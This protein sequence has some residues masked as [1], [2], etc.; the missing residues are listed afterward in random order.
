VNV[1]SYEPFACLAGG[2]F[3][4]AACPFLRNT[5]IAFSRS[6]WA[7]IN[8]AR[9]SL[10]PAFVRPQL[11]HELGWNFH[12]VFGVLILFSLLSLTFS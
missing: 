11:L 5:A 1:A 6:P 12:A 9:Q 7:S 3:A 2:F 4:A 10:N 8:A